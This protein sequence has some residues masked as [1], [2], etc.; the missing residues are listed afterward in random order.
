MARAVR[1]VWFSAAEENFDTTNCRDFAPA[2]H[3]GE[4]AETKVLTRFGLKELGK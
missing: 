2:R 4:G 1:L 3:A